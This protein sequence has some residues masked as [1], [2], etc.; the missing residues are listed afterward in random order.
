MYICTYTYIFYECVFACFDHNSVSTLWVLCA[1]VQQHHLRHVYS[2]PQ[3]TAVF[4][5][6]LFPSGEGDYSTRHAACPVLVG[7]KWGE[8]LSNNYSKCNIF[9][10]YIESYVLKTAYRVISR[11]VVEWIV[12]PQWE[13]ELHIWGKW[14]TLVRWLYPCLRKQ[15]IIKCKL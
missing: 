12:S 3:G 2:V 14:P 11:C 7:N 1:W 10:I 15:S 5:Y 13:R 4:W 8:C 9:W 6:N